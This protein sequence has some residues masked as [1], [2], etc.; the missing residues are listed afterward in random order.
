MKPKY[1]NSLKGRLNSLCRGA[2]RSAKVKGF[3]FDIDADDLLA[4]WIA[5]DGKCAYTDWEMSTITG[6]LRIVS[7]E[8]K[9]NSK[10]YLKDNFL[11]VCWCVNRARNTLD[12]N[13]FVEMCKAVSKKA[14]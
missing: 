3:S 5:Q 9:D 10:G 8:R 13:F 6:D 12:F 7:I 14:K 11:L 1:E 4:C 2:R